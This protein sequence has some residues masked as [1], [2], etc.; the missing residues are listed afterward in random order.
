[1]IL[2]EGIGTGLMS[3]TSYSDI[4][5]ITHDREVDEEIHAGDL[6]RTGPNLFP[7]FEVIAIHG[8]K[9]W[10][11]N[12]QSGVDGLTPITRCRKINGAP[13]LDSL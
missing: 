8:D 13:A 5:S 2:G 6:V 1:M 4:Y 12:V 9:C 3:P 11:R 7:H 10:V